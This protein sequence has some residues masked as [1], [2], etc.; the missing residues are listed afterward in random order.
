MCTFQNSS[1]DDDDD[2][3]LPEEEE[4]PN[5]K[6]AAGIGKLV[7]DKDLDKSIEERLDMLH[8]F[9]VEAKEKGTIGDG[10]VRS[11]CGLNL[12][13]HSYSRNRTV[14][15]NGRRSGASRTEAK[16]SASSCRCTSRP[17]HH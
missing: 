10:K 12:A 7:I 15:G 8:R 14:P 11:F 3:W 13:L 4:V 16:S 2:D 9:F 17:G 1:N 6:L 5:T